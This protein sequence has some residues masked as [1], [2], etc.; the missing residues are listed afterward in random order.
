MHF[1]HL[2]RY[3]TYVLSAS[4]PVMTGDRV[5]RPGDQVTPLSKEILSRTWSLSPKT[6]S[7]LRLFDRSKLF[8]AQLGTISAAGRAPKKHKVRFGRTPK[9]DACA[10]L[11]S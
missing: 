5:H 6:T 9:P 11:I 8:A 2:R 1:P 10:P 7:A 4:E 3:S